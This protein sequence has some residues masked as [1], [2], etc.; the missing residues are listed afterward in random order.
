MRQECKTLRPVCERETA[1]PERASMISLDIALT[2]DLTPLLTAL[3]LIL[4]NRFGPPAD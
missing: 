1:A 4:I 2:A 3:A